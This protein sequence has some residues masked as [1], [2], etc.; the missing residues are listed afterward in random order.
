MAGSDCSSATRSGA[1]GASRLTYG[2]GARSGASET[3]PTCVPGPFRAGADI[4]SV[5]GERSTGAPPS[6][7]SA[8]RRDTVPRASLI[9]TARASPIHPTIAGR[10]SKLSAS[11][12]T[13]PFT[14]ETSSTRNVSAY[15]T[16]ASETVTATQRPSGDHAGPPSAAGV[17]TS[18]RV[19]PVATSTT[20]TSA[21]TQSSPAGEGEC[22]KAIAAPSG[23]E[24]N[25]GPLIPAPTFPPTW[26][27]C[28]V[29][30]RS[31]RGE[32]QPAPVRRPGR[33]ARR[34]LDPPGGLLAGGTDGIQVHGRPPLARLRFHER[35]GH[36]DRRPAPVRRHRH[37]PDALDRERQL[38]RPARDWGL[39]AGCEEE[40]QG[41]G[42]QV[43]I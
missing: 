11:G 33:G 22:E 34:R 19:L 16:G 1:N 40:N 24:S 36:F 5:S 39:H 6:A 25:A 42:H 18:D 13:A 32:R 15:V 26:T 38:R 41:C 4:M 20:D 28:G 35:L 30:T 2:S 14:G 31:A 37:A 27:S 7:G 17:A 9:T 10:R 23:A 29:S 12:R 3:N 21:R 43:A 8:L